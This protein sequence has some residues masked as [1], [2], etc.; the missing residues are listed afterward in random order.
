M[1]II[2][3]GQLD[4]L[5]DYLRAPFSMKPIRL[6]SAVEQTA[7]Y[8]R[9]GLRQGRWR[10]RLPGVVRLAAECLVSKGVVRAALRQL[11][12][13]G[14]LASRGQG[15]SRTVAVPGGAGAPQRSLR[16]GILLFEREDQHVGY[17]VELQ[18]ALATAG[19]VT[20]FADKSQVDLH[21]EVRR[22]LR[23][24]SQTP[25]DAWVVSAGSREILQ[26]FAA[27]PV[28]AIALFG[29]RNGVP[30]ASSGPDKVPAYTEATRQLLRHGHRRIVLLCRKLRRLPE[31]GRIE[32]AFLA[33]LAAQGCPVS[34]F[35]LP[36]WEE[37]GAGFHALLGALFRSTPPTALIVDEAPLFIATQ[38]FL[39]GRNLLVPKHVSLVSA[40]Y[41]PAFEWC[42]P[43]IS[44]MRWDFGPVIQ[45]IVRW[46][47]AVS[48]H[49]PDLKQALFPAEFVT[50]GT[51][52]P[53]WKG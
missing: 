34:D 36:D 5:V 39:A 50:G 22:V 20:F 18:H 48:Q 47:A 12:T 21:F 38:Q 52:G 46:A 51:I 17:M 40:D 1:Q 2:S 44:H 6:L 32:R 43:A 14:L 3:F 15:R 9:E 25:A 27:Q 35:N 33:E 30:I 19:H 26:W 11:E 7:A 16:V 42:Q 8:L 29:R 24:V 37:T 45:R 41:D 4:R 49:R 13:E 28:P 23:Q 53:V 31:P 10:G